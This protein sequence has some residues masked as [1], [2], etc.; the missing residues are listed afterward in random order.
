MYKKSL[1]FLACSATLFLAGCKSTSDAGKNQVAPVPVVAV[2]PQIS[3]LTVY[4]EPIGSLSASM[5]MEIRPQVGGTLRE[6]LVQEGER[7]TAGQPLFKVDPTPYANKVQEAEAQLAIDEAGYLA[8]QKKWGR[9]K[10]LAEKNLVAQTEWDEIQATLTKAAAVVELNKARLNTAKLDLDRSVVRSP[11]DGT[12]GKIDINPGALVSAG[13]STPL[14]IVSN[15]DTLVVEFALTEK[16]FARIPPGMTKIEMQSLCASGVCKAG[17]ITFFDNQFDPKTGLLLVRGQV[18]NKGGL[19]RPGQTVRINVPVSVTTNAV[20]IP[21][22][23]IKYNQ[24]GPYVYVVQPD[25][26]IAMRQLILGT[27]QSGRVVVVE[28]LEPS[29]KIVLEGH[30]RIAPGSKVEIQS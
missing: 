19:L 25:K 24:Q 17:E 18:S 6:V 23:A 13:Q 10:E 8:A 20:L 27:E 15:I 11:V 26:T 29:E 28:G 2:A 3:D 14:T 5:R 30:L 16:E 12:V 21:V 22:K 1:I 4:L 9:F 7:V